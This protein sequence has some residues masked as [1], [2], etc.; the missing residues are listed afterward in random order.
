MSP[1]SERNY[2]LA[3][4][5]TGAG[6]DRGVTLHMSMAELATIRT[7][8]DLLADEHAYVAAWDLLEALPVPTDS[9]PTPT[10]AWTPAVRDGDWLART[11]ITRHCARAR[12]D[13]WLGHDAVEYVMASFGGPAEPHPIRALTI[14][15]QPPASSEPVNADREHVV[16]LSQVQTQA[17]TEWL[18]TKRNGSWLTNH[19]GLTV[20]AVENGG[21]LVRTRP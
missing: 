16:R 18:A 19:A 17:L 13:S 6:T 9:E 3:T 15:G 14:I 1:M 21:I 7:A 4:D 11:V 5:V 20:K 8:L 12:G 10:P 2:Q